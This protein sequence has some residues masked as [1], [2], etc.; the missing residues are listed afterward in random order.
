M[1]GQWQRALLDTGRRNRIIH[2]RETRRATLGNLANGGRGIGN[3][4][5]SDLINPLSRFL[6][7]EDIRGNA[8]IH[9][10]DIDG[11]FTVA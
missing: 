1:I 8:T 5:E 7:D 11:P 2:Y 10:Q 6:F 9:V 3:I 4:V